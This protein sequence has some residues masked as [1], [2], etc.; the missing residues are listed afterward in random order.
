MVRCSKARRAPDYTKW[1]AHKTQ[2][3][4][5]LRKVEAHFGN[6]DSGYKEY[7][8]ETI[9]L[10]DDSP[11]KAVHQPWNQLVLPEYDRT[12]YQAT[13]QAIRQSDE[14]AGTDCDQYLLAVIGILEATSSFENIPSWIRAGGLKKPDIHDLATEEEQN[15]EWEEGWGV[16]RGKPDGPAAGV[17]PTLESLPTHESF[18]HWFQDPKLVKRWIEKGKEALQTAGIAIEHGIDPAASV[19]GSPAPTSRSDWRRGGSAPPLPIGHS[20]PS[21]RQRGYSPSRPTSPTKAGEN[22]QPSDDNRNLVEEVPQSVQPLKQNKNGPIAASLS[23]TGQARSFSTANASYDNAPN[24]PHPISVRNDRPVH[25]DT[26]RTFRSADVASYLGTLTKRQTLKKQDQKILGAASRLLRRLNMEIMEDPC[27]DR[28][29]PPSEA[30]ARRT[31]NSMEMEE[32]EVDEP[33]PTTR[34]AEIVQIHGSMAP[35]QGN[36]RNRRDSAREDRRKESRPVN[37][38]R[39]S[40]N[41]AVDSGYNPADEESDF[42]DNID[43]S[44]PVGARVIIPGTV[45]SRTRGANAGGVLVELRPDRRIAEPSRMNGFNPNVSGRASNPHEPEVWSADDLGPANIVYPL[46]H[47]TSDLDLPPAAIDGTTYSAAEVARFFARAPSNIDPTQQGHLR[48]IA[49][50]EIGIGKARQRKQQG[51]KLKCNIESETN[52]IIKLRKCVI[53]IELIRDQR[54]AAI[55][56]RHKEI[57]WHRARGL[58]PP[59]DRSLSPSLKPPKTKKDKKPN[60]LVK[61][62]VSNKKKT[63]HKALNGQDGGMNAGAGPPGANNSE[64]GSRSSK[65]RATDDG[66]QPL[67]KVQRVEQ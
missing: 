6:A 27:W 31:G 21:A 35:V 20:V 23:S 32:G 22:E 46:D 52:R 45:S 34:P 63:K 49:M 30:G 25:V 29:G 55:R 58:P 42:D 28:W 61:P 53:K 57:E 38:T 16:W 1:P 24:V 4:K 12:A 39:Q 56:E 67:N 66:D 13:K 36:S 37:D 62:K 5:D 15:A 18:E 8:L 3:T 51:Q 11:L 33:M 9:L 14:T 26:W 48:E 41:A 43:P 54:D 2:T 60:D 40:P 17:P 10:L 19:R 59:P 7:P 65:R 64:Q 47:P 44:I 50:R